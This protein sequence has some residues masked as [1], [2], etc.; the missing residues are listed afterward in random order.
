[1]PKVCVCPNESYTCEVKFATLLILSID[2][3]EIQYGRIGEATYHEVGNF[4]VRLSGINT[5]ESFL[6]NFTSTLSVSDL[7]ANGSNL[8]CEGFANPNTTFDN[9]TVCVI[10][11]VALNC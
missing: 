1:M 9:I 7:A 8:T 11:K 4:R 10:G 6:L 3:N 2:S 5:A